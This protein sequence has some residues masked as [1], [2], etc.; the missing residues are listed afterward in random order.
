MKKVFIIA[1]LVFLL[2]SGFY[3]IKIKNRHSSLPTK[4]TTSQETPKKKTLLDLIKGKEGVEC[5]IENAGGKIVMIAQTGR[6][7]V[8]GY[9]LP[10][11]EGNGKTSIINDGNWVYIWSEGE[12][13]GIKYAV[14]EEDE[15]NSSP[16]S[17][18][19]LKD[20][21]KAWQEQHYQCHPKRLSDADFQPPANVKFMDINQLSIPSN[22]PTLPQK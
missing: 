6:V 5:Q 2:G 20:T 12:E 14:D 9:S 21:L 1:A 19:S 13:R 17:S 18:F 7:K 4:E 16:F 22:M 11:S 8:T 15:E 10:G 3:F